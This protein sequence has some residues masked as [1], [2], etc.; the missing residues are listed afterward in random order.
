[1]ATSLGKTCKACGSPRKQSNI[2]YHPD[3]FEAYCVNPWICNTEHPN[4]PENLIKRGKELQLLTFEEAE[5]A[6]GSWLLMNHPDKDKAEKIRRLV[7]HPTTVRVG[8][9][10]NAE[11]LVNLVDELGLQSISDAMRFC[12]QNT[13]EQFHSYKKDLGQRTEVKRIE[14]QLTETSQELTDTLNKPAAP[15]PQPE[16]PPQQQPESESAE[17]ASE[18]TE[19]KSADFLGSF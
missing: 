18:D 4:S 7:T 11:F 14:D 12:V 2:G 3:T 17:S 1:M 8:S 16:Q 6:F 5:E 15:A 19:Q 9:P 13:R 10:E